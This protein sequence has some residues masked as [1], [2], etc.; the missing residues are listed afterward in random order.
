M[1]ESGM[2]M[3]NSYLSFHDSNSSIQHNNFCKVREW[4]RWYTLK[5]PV[6]FGT[7]RRTVNFLVKL[8]K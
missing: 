3:R 7:L 4:K 2:R 1:F 8:A 6:Q 5:G